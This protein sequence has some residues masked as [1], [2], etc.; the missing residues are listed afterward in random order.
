[1][2]EAA[3][4]PTEIAPAWDVTWVVWLLDSVALPPVPPEPLLPLL[5]E[6]PEVDLRALLRSTKLASEASAVA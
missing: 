5:D 6:L 3:R 4:L 1:M 2:N